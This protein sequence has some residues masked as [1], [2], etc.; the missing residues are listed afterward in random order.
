MISGIIKAIMT[1]VGLPMP[2]DFTLLSALFLSIDIVLYSMRRRGK[3]D[4]NIKLEVIPILLLFM[5]YFWLLITSIYTASTEYGY[6]KAVYF[7]LNIL[8]FLY[9]III[10][11]FNLRRFVRWLIGLILIFSLLFLP[12][13]LLVSS[14]GLLQQ[15][16]SAEELEVIS[17]HYLS[18]GELAGFCLVFLI[19]DSAKDYFP[20]YLLYI[21]KLLF[22]VILLG[23]GAR[24]PLLFALIVV[25]FILLSKRYFFGFRSPKRSLFI[26]GLSFLTLGLLIFQFWDYLYPLF[27]NTFRRLEILANSAFDSSTNDN[28]IGERYEHF[29]FTS[30]YIFDNFFDFLFGQGVGS[31]GIL[32]KGFDVRFYPHNIVLELLFEFG[33]IGLLLFGIWFGTTL[34]NF[35]ITVI[36]F[37]FF[38]CLIFSCLNLLKSNSLVDI[39]LFFGTLAVLI[40]VLQK[41]NQGEREILN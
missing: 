41:S 26:G 10:K 13:H 29:R 37:S 9:P 32:F 7:L 31:Y 14:S 18:L 1:F 40:I 30:N 28:S 15:L 21:L 33:L 25:V 27:E 24:G 22:L 17:G 23:L 19:G 35:N 12:F 6:V 38:W 5:F 36:R 3:I 20:K 2:V 34:I 11:D 8:A 16:Y 39:R 4:L